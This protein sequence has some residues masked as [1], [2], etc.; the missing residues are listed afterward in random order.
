MKVLFLD[1][2]G[3][4]ALD[5]QFCMNRKKFHFKNPK[6]RALRIPYPFDKSAVDVLNNILQDTKATIVLSSDWRLYWNLEDTRK[7]FEFNGV[8]K[9]PEFYTEKLKDFDLHTSEMFTHKGWSERIRCLEICKFL[10]DHPE[11]THWVVVDDLN[12]SN[13][14]LKPGL[15]NFVLIPRSDEGIKQCGIKEKI[16]NFLN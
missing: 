8:I 13:E 2:D 14:F 7:I 10:E 16:I 11:I 4:I 12:M 1:I 15:D 3:V 6:A 9:S 5:T